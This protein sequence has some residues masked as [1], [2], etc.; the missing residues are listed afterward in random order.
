MNEIK[1]IQSVL[2]RL[3]MM[4]Y[5]T[6]YFVGIEDSGYT[7]LVYIDDNSTTRVIHYQNNL[8]DVLKTL[9]GMEKYS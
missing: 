9:Q 1:Q 3:N 2:S 7:I 4:N 6:R 5:P 8:S